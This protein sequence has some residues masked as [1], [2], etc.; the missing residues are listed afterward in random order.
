[1]PASPAPRGPARAAPPPS[2][3]VRRRGRASATATSRTTRPGRG[4]MTTTRSP[5][6]TAS[7]TSWVTS[8]TVR[9]SVA[10]TCA[11]QPCISARVI[12]SSAANGSSSA[13][14]GLPASSER[15]NETR[16]RMPPESWAG[17]ACSKPVR[18][19]RSSHGAA[20][21]RA[22]AAAHAPRAQRQRGIVDGAQPRQQQIALG[23]QR[24]RGA[25]HRAGVGRLQAADE[26]EQRRLAAPAGA[27]DG[28]DLA[29]R[30][31]Q[32]HV[33]QGLHRRPCAT[34]TPCSPVPRAPRRC[35]AALRPGELE[36]RSSR[37]ERPRISLRGHYPTGSKGQRRAASSA[38]GAISAGVPASPP[39]CQVCAR[40]ASATR[41]RRAPRSGQA[42]CQAAPVR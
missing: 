23:H 31:P 19:K 30:G 12:A 13:S 37:V 25:R 39:G 3:S 7:S 1:M 14:T 36:P 38:G 24:R 33:G 5:S 26:L 40:D 6:T 8:T 22:S 41:P 10:R 35:H 18:P 42:P 29:R 32:R 2:A 11:S 9:G 17:R 28:D 16:W 4:D 34:R 21:A 20:A 27:D 15:R